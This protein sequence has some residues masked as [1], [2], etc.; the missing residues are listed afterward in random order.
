MIGSAEEKAKV[1]EAM[2]IFVLGCIVVFGAFGFWKVFVTI[3]Q[4]LSK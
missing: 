1:K 2:V 3:G 4:S